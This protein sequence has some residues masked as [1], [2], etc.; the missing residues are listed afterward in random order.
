MG[1][2]L[3]PVGRRADVL[4]ALTEPQLRAGVGEDVGAFG[5]AGVRRH[6][7]HC[8]PGEQATHHGHHRLQ[9][10][11]GQHR[12]AVRPGDVVG[13]RTG[14]ATQLAAGQA[15]LAHSHR[16]RMVGAARLQ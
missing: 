13:H 8:D 7:N 3:D 6:R 4:W 9:A 5:G 16:S 12:H 14:R 1:T 10:R 2:Q 15:R 11:R